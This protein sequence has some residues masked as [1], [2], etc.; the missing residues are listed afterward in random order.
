LIELI[1][2]YKYILGVCTQENSGISLR[3]SHDHVQ[4]SF[5]SSF[6]L[7]NSSKYNQATKDSQRI[8]IEITLITNCFDLTQSS[9]PSLQTNALKLLGA[10]TVF[11]NL[12][13]VIVLKVVHDKHQHELIIGVLVV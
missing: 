6:C 4:A 8:V 13:V 5:Q 7:H 11:F 3:Q 1:Y 9:C 12:V 2:I 10:V